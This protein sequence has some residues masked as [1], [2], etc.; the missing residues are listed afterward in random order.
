MSQNTFPFAESEDAVP[1][2]EDGERSRKAVLV[3]GGVAAALVLGAGGW[4]LLGGNSSST[5]AAFVSHRPAARPAAVKPKAAP[6]AV[7]K[8]LPTAYKAPLGRDPFRAL[9]VLPVAAPAPT[10]APVAAA[11]PATTGTTGTTS[12]TPGTTTATSRY[13]LK[14]VSISKP[15]PEVRFFTWLVDGKKTVVIPAQRFGKV[16]ELVV[17]AYTKNAAGNATGAVIQVGDDSPIDVLIG[18]SVSV[19]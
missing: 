3:A 9:Y 19:L 7:V 15:Q 1:P 18:E 6:K 10:A 14:L 12:T 2:V 17:L 5:D 13:P 11:P 16:G 8:K 4:F